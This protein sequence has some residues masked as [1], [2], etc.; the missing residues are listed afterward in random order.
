MGS[1]MGNGVSTNMSLKGIR[2]RVQTLFYVHAI[3]FS[4]SLSSLGQPCPPPNAQIQVHRIYDAAGLIFDM[5]MTQGK[6]VS[7]EAHVICTGTKECSLLLPRPMN[8]TVTVGMN[9]LKPADRRRVVLRPN[10]SSCP[11]ILISGCFDGSHI[12]IDSLTIGA[13]QACPILDD[14]NDYDTTTFR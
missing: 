9:Q 7:V 13:E 2:Q 4:Y 11:P 3:V 10:P 14:I 1:T 6:Y 5:E 12:D 8:E